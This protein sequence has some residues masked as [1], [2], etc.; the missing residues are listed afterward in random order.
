MAIKSNIHDRKVLI[1]IWFNKSFITLDEK[2]YTNIKYIC[3]MNVKMP[4]Q[5]RRRHLADNIINMSYSY[6]WELYTFVLLFPKS[7]KACVWSLELF[8]TYKEKQPK[9]ETFFISLEV[10]LIY[11]DLFVSSK[12]YNCCLKLRLLNRVPQYYYT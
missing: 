11:S 3:K 2:M 8:T 5:K 1:D 10:K 9:R 7:Q 6:Y 12:Q 4:E